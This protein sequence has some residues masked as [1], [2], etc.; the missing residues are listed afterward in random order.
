MPETEKYGAAK[1]YGPRYGR[2]LKE[3]FEKVEREQRKKH[4]CPY[5]SAVKVKRLALGIWKCGKCCAKFT[6]KAYSVT[7]K[8]TFEKSSEK[9]EEKIPQVDTKQKETKEVAQDG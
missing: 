4:K 2:K 1:R 5:C 8:I 6:G 9:P 7:K 3:K